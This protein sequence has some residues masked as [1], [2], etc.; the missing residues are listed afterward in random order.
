M[1]IK[2]NET[3]GTMSTLGVKMT[4]YTMDKKRYTSKLMD[5][6]NPNWREEGEYY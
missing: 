5:A 2:E 6:E 3:R 1:K 4:K